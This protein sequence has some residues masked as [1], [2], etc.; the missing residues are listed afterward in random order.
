MDPNSIMEI[1]CIAIIYQHKKTHFRRYK[2]FSLAKKK[3]ISK[4]ENFFV[5]SNWNI[6]ENW[7]IKNVCNFQKKL[8]FWHEKPVK[9]EKLL[10]WLQFVI[11]WNVAIFKCI[12]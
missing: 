2:N 5:I 1:F 9:I 10:S 3:R 7:E 11:L 4:S 8:I 12:F 6:Y